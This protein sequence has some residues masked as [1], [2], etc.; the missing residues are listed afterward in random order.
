[1]VKRKNVLLCNGGGPTAVM[2]LTN[3]GVIEGCLDYGLGNVSLHASLAGTGGLIGAHATPD[4]KRHVVNLDAQIADNYQRQLIKNTPSTWIGS[5]RYKLGSV[6]K[7]EKDE[8]AEAFATRRRDAI[9]ADIAKVMEV[10]D[11]LKIDHV[12]FV[13]G[14]DTLTTLHALS[15]YAERHPREAWPT[16]LSVPKTIDNDLP[17]EVA[18][19]EGDE[20]IEGIFV[21][22]G[23]VKVIDACP[24]F[25]TAANFVANTVAHLAVEALA[26]NRHYVI[27]IMGRNA[28][29]LTAASLVAKQF[30]YGPHL[31]AVPEHGAFDEQQF[32]E[33]VLRCEKQQGFG[34]YCVSEGIEDANGDPVGSPKRE[35]GV[36]V[37]KDPFGHARL[38]GV[39][40][41]LAEVAKAYCQAHGSKV[42][43]R[44]IRPAEMQRICVTFR[45]QA[46]AEISYNVGHRAA[47][48]GLERG[49]TGNLVTIVRNPGVL[50]SW[51][52]GLVPTPRVAKKKRSMDE[53]WIDWDK[54]YD[55]KVPTI[56]KKYL[57]Y[58]SPLID[59]VVPIAPAIDAPELD[60]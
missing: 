31:I 20:D 35:A 57:D 2:N 5:G 56:D 45:S 14:D 50:P 59:P 15:D 27:E 39:G 6:A 38:G 9:D 28:G 8:S 3:I 55:C 54:A 18:A 52:H 53:A 51:S 25:G 21:R 36:E 37:E 12:F 4:G 26:L 41:Y 60:L 19:V 13:G 43:A 33:F 58:L 40:A 1:M 34:V 7:Q 30:G 17:Y 23:Q 47:Y 11:S 10:C 22:D 46:D 32:A 48:W 24:G 16:F 42:D 49:Q 29:F 44:G